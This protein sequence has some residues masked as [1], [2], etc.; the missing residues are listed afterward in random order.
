MHHKFAM[1]KCL[2]CPHISIS[3]KNVE[4]IGLKGNIN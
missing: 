4:N 3:D 1:V 2:N